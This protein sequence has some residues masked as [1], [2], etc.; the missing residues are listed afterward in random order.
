[1][2]EK[3]QIAILIAVA[4]GI[5]LA[6]ALLAIAVPVMFEGDL[7]IAD[8]Q[9]G[10]REDGTFT[11]TY[12]YEVK[13][14]GRYRML[15]RYWNEP[16]ALGP[17]SVPSL[18]LKD[19][20]VPAGTIGYVKEYDGTVSLF[21]EEGSAVPPLITT[22]AEKNEVGIYNPAYFS[23]G[24]YQVTYTY[25][26]H[27]PLEYDES[28]AHL[29]LRLVDDQHIPFRSLLISVPAGVVEKVYPHPP[30]LS[31]SEEGDLVKISGSVPA[32]EVMGIE[33]LLSKDALDTIPG[34]PVF[35]PDVAGQ[36][37]KANPWYDILPSTIAKV[38]YFLGFA[39]ALVTPLIL[40]YTYYRYGRE[41]EFTVPEYLS[42]IPNPSMKPWEVN[43][44]FKGDA[45]VFDEDG[46]YATL[47][48]LHSKKVV[49][50]SEE[51]GGQNV[52]IRINRNVSADP[53]EQRVLSF[54]GEI[55]TDGLVNSADLEI[56]AS[57]AKTDPAAE[58][59]MLAYQQ[60]LS[61]VSRK[62]DPALSAKYVMDGR[63]HIFPLLFAGIVFCA[64]SFFMIILFGTLSPLL[65]P[66][67]ILFGSIIVQSGVALAFPST[68]FGHWKGET[69]KEK[70]E[71]DAFAKFL[72]DLAMIRKYSPSD[73]AMWGE[74]LVYGTALGAGDSVE[75][76][77]KELNISIPET[78]V[79]A[80]GVRSAFIP[81]LFFA[82]PSRGGGGSSGG[83]GGGGVGG[84]GGFG[85]GGVGGR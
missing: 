6:A 17:L 61:L 3:R 83:F 44:L 50:I 14:A 4:F 74:W 21:G 52:R 25:V 9:A 30:S 26:L 47:L 33:M 8:Y 82:P 10:L 62:S 53:Y 31:V 80:T 46:Y 72:S 40:L 18:E 11:E 60:H 57:R 81:V 39:A 85:G 13:V 2:D 78:M 73:I 5:A 75:K 77:M 7:V 43:L 1:V 41:K 65:V 23:P 66:A 24:M 27:P 58:R 64:L 16:L 34:F 29:N 35:T 32:N 68:L 76:A 19:A 63:E 55:A 12:L 49:T 37:A 79:P 67:V 38:L 69:Y 59:K 45:M 22:L 51:E 28:A 71:W 84:G 48:D 54:L 56:L 42:T 36:T 20:Q 70:L 15:Y